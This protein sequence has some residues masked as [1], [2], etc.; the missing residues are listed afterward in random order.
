MSEFC[1]E[2]H[3]DRPVAETAVIHSW[4]LPMFR[5]LH[6]DADEIQY[7]SYLGWNGFTIKTMVCPMNP[8][9]I[10]KLSSG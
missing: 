7:L 3:Y 6:A 1:L 9:A 10:G 4:P 8:T 2:K 5:Y